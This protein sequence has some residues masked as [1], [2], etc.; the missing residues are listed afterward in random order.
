GLLRDGMWA[1]VVVFDPETVIDRATYTDP[2]H[3]SVGIRVVFVNGSAV[4]R[5]GTHTGAHPGRRVNGP[6]YR[7]GL[8]GG[9]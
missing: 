7:Q 5:D 8:E 6:G 1:D 4:L 2:H 3:L 9:A